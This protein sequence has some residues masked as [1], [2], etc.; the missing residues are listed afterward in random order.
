MLLLLFTLY[1]FT[2]LAQTSAYLPSLSLRIND[3]NV[4]ESIIDLCL[5]AIPNLSNLSSS[6][7]YRISKIFSSAYHESYSE[8]ADALKGLKGI[9]ESFVL[10]ISPFLKVLSPA[11][12]SDLVYD[13]FKVL[14]K[15]ED[16][17]FKKVKD[18]TGIDADCSKI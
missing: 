4:L 18:M 9:N 1:E 12:S 15:L 3:K 7:R 6:D 8:L 10:A 5:L 14:Q 11:S 17:F 13:P 2:F 16:E